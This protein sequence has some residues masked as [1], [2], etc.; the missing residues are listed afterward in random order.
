MLDD[1]AF[2]WLWEFVE[3]KG[4]QAGS[5]QGRGY[6]EPFVEA[7][8]GCTQ[9]VVDAFRDTASGHPNLKE[10]RQQRG[11]TTPDVE[12]PP[13][14]KRKLKAKRASKKVAL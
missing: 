2:Q 14:P 6:S 12:E 8:G 4:R 11:D 5:L 7:Y 10:V 9:R 3:S 13:V 1:G